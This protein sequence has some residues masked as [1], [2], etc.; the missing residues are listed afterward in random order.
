MK[1]AFA[2]LF[3]L[4]GV[5]V[6]DDKA[7]EKLLKDIGGSYTVVAVEKGGEQAPAE[8]MKSFESITIKGN[9]LVIS[10]K[11]N[12]KIEE[13]IAVLIVDASKK[14]VHVDLKPQDSPKKNDETFLGIVETAE[15]TI[16]FCW[17]EGPNAKRPTDF[18][19]TKD[20]KN[21]LLTFKRSS[22]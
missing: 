7:N 17:G 14:P 5:A 6:A 10:F 20:N 11:E 4:G 12:G 3:F 8:F 9:K 15:D 22:K 13:K 16:K 19:S 2:A 18:T 21:F 1:F